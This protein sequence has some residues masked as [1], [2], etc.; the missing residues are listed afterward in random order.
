MKT[1]RSDG[2]VVGSA[3]R[4]GGGTCQRDDVALS[5]LLMCNILLNKY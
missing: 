4:S 1:R 3:T 5:R 2:G